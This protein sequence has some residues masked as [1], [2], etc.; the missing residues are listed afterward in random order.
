MIDFLIAFGICLVGFFLHWAKRYLRK[1]T[2]SNL[3]QYLK[4]FWGH[5]VA[6]LGSI[7]GAVIAVA[8]TGD[9]NIHDPMTVASL[10]FGGYTLDSMMNKDIDPENPYAP[11]DNTYNGGDIP[12]HDLVKDSAYYEEE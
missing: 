7:L 2:K 11:V 9:L 6:S 10:V 1:Q 5:T 12:P 4:V 3:L 8:Q